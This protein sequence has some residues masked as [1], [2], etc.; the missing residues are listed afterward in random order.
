MQQPTLPGHVR[1]DDP[2]LT[3]LEAAT[4]EALV[5]ATTKTTA[6]K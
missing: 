1:I 3:A 2:A 6:A 5:A 4:I